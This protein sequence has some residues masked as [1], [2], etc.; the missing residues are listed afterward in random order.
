MDA[1]GETRR[2]H[3]C[4]DLSLLLSADLEAAA[5][6][7][8]VFTTEVQSIKVLLRHLY[9]DA[10]GAA[11][12]RGLGLD[13]TSSARL[14]ARGCERCMRPVLYAACV[15][16]VRKA[17]SVHLTKFS[18]AAV[19]QSR[20]NLALLSTKFT[21]ALP[22]L[23]FPARYSLCLALGELGSL[24]VVQRMAQAG[25]NVGAEVLIGAADTC[26]IADLHSL[27]VGVLSQQD[28]D[29]EICIEIGV[30]LA[31]FGDD[32]SCL[33]WLAAQL[34]R[35]SAWPAHFIN[36]VCNLAAMWANIPTLQFL[37][38]RGPALFGTLGTL[39]LSD[40]RSTLPNDALVFVDLGGT[41]HV[42]TV[43]DA[44]AMAA[45]PTV[46]QWLHSQHAAEFTSITMQEAASNAVLPS[47]K[48]LHQQGCAY[49]INQILQL[50]L[51]SVYVTP[52][53]V[54]WVRSFGGGDW[55]PQG[56]TDMLATA[57][58]RSTPGLARWLRV[59]GAPWP[60]N[61]AQLV[62]RAGNYV[63]PLT[64]LWAVQ[65]GCPFGRWTTRVCERLES[66]SASGGAVKRAL[67]DLGCP[68]ACPRPPHQV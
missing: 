8:P 6:D 66:S 9:P 14:C 30:S 46:L 58:L 39:F 31:R 56:M 55:S 41:E 40:I 15:A 44:A 47:L 22:T 48:W 33:S 7:L 59:E 64:I 62:N 26:N 5:A 34:R 57:L 61:L 54:A 63:K 67:H 28:V 19:S 68:C 10:V 50:V 23:S 29:L 45:N 18:A 42:L 25:L 60:Q 37:L 2:T 24:E 36:E 4:A 52:P 20:L 43:V 1:G 35:P 13:I 65:H 38:A 21:D 12:M 27:W 16:S 49:D 17:T 3:C 32:G 51:V 53:A 11:P